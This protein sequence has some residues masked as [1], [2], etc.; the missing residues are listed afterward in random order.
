MNFLV[1]DFSQVNTI[2]DLIFAIILFAIVLVFSVRKVNKIFACIFYPTVYAVIILGFIFQLNLLTYAGLAIF[3]IGSV[4][5]LFVN[6]SEYR[7]F[8]QKDPNLRNKKKESS[9]DKQSVEDC[10]KI[11]AETVKTL[12][13]TKT[14]ALMT[15]E[16]TEE[17]DIKNG[18]KI[19]APVSQELLVTI[20]YP[21]TRLHDGA[22][23]ISGTEIIAA[24]VF[25][26]PTT[27]ALA[28]KYG[29]RHRAAVGIAEVSDSVT[30]VVSEETGRISLAYKSR[31]EHTT[32]DDFLNDF[33]DCMNAKD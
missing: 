32:A 6:A 15:F 3:V 4:I 14:G 10:Y 17:I 20:F 8:I 30:V 9:K 7:Y 19:N 2:L 13:R 26:T 11:I 24:S 21:G 33:I 28:G 18:V 31:L 5:S 1:V 29:S 12:S 27:R 16:K 22:V 23:V 25:Y